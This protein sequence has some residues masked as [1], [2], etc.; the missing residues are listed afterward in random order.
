MSQVQWTDEIVW[1]V[2]KLIWESRGTEEKLSANADAIEAVAAE[3]VAAKADIS[4]KV[5]A[6]TAAVGAGEDLTQ[7]LADLKAAA[8]GVAAIAP[9]APGADAPT[10]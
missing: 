1:Y 8:D 4:A 2:A 6:L 7:P 10:A 9:P 3:L 5:D